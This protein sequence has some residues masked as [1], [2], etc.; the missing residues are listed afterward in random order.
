MLVATAFAAGILV[1][2]IVMVI[3]ELAFGFGRRK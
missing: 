1:S 3:V 2:L